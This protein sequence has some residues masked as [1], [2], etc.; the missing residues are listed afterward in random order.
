MS[1]TQFTRKLSAKL[2]GGLLFLALTASYASAATTGSAVADYMLTQWPDLN[3][4]SCGTSCFS[5]N[6]ATVPATPSLKGWEYTNGFPLAAMWR[7]YEKTGNVKYYNY[8]KKFV[9]SYV[10]SSGSVPTSTSQDI[11]QPAIL[12]TGLYDATK[13][14]RYLTAMKSVRS[15]VDSIKMNSA[16]AFWHKSNYSNQQWLDGLYMTEPFL[17]RYASKY[18]DSVTAGDAAVAFNI[19]T[20]Q[21]KIAQERLFDTS[22]KLPYHA[23]NG[24][25]DGVWAG[26]AAGSGKTP[27]LNGQVVSPIL[28]SRSIGWYFAALIDV[29]EYLPASHAD[30]AQL[31]ALANS[32]AQGL[33]AQQDAS[34]GLWYQVIDVRNSAL[35]ANGGYSGESVT[36][37][38][39]WT[40]TSASALFAY[41]LA[42]G[43][44]LGILPASSRTVADKAWVGVKSKIT[45]SG[46][47]VTISGAVAGMGVGGTYNAY[48]NADVRTDLSSGALPAPK[49][50]CSSLPTTFT[51]MPLACKYIYIRNNVPH[52]VG[53]VL[54]AST[55][56]EY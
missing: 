51:S 47:T 13:D 27:P 49:A 6:Y 40:E 36:A 23:W 17:A 48:V 38:A 44:R 35:P 28:W 3:S 37:Q 39:N 8:V 1:P 21:F 24:A 31:L 55:E 43:V 12:L 33:A 26:L 34:T 11:I 29:L 52:V 20:K 22:K 25:T 15:S 4:T 50:Q 16:G 42:K 2:A 18:A 32:L 19:V 54:F 30:R 10:T 46:S 53:A 7:M 9:D 5:L 45:I 14:A 56:L 41:G